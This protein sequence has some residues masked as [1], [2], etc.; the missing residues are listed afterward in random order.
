M[1]TSGVVLVLRP[2]S[3]RLGL[4]LEA[5]ADDRKRVAAP[6]PAMDRADVDRMISA[7]ESLDR[8]LTRI[9]ERQE[10]TEALLHR[11]EPGQLTAG[12]H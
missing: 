2:I 7:M 8:R 3:K 4:F 1:V 12:K 9:E 5:L 11:A 6:A 10:F